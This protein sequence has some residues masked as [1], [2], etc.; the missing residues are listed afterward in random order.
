[1]SSAS[2]AGATGGN[3]LS[4][5]QGMA[6]GNVKPKIE[7]RVYWW[8]VFEGMGL[9][10]IL[11]RDEQDEAVVDE[12]VKQIGFACGRTFTDLHPRAKSPDG[13]VYMETDRAEME[14][15]AVST[16]ASLGITGANTTVYMGH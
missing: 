9:K 5:L 13:R 8:N 10:A 4:R 16:L 14:R 7:G 11:R 3:L 15:I 6:D 12:T 1:L 2:S